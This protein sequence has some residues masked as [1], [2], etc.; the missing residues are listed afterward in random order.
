MILSRDAIATG[1]CEWWFWYARIPPSRHASGMINKS[2]IN[3]CGRWLSGCVANIRLSPASAANLANQTGIQPPAVRMSPFA[4]WVGIYSPSTATSLFL[5]FL[6]QSFYDST[7]LKPN[8]RIFRFH[9]PFYASTF[10]RICRKKKE[11][12]Y[13]HIY[14]FQRSFD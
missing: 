13:T 2:E 10:Y 8:F 6:R 12:K 11:A 4:Q 7:I 9:F 1:T 5:A 14:S 3:R